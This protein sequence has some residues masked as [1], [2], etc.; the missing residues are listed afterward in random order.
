MNQHTK[1]GLD[2]SFKFCPLDW[3]WALVFVGLRCLFYKQL[4]PRD[5]AQLPAAI[6]LQA[7]VY[8]VVVE[9]KPWGTYLFWFIS[10]LPARKTRWRFQKMPDRE[11]EDMNLSGGGITRRVLEE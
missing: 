5:Y 6:A 9:W 4:L 1:A 8:I 7:A 2:P 11:C 10:L 3:G